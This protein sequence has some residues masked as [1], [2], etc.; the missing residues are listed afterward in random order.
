MNFHLKRFHISRDTSEVVRHVIKQCLQAFYHHRNWFM[1][2]SMVN[3]IESWNGK[4]EIFFIN[5]RKTKVNQKTCIDFLKTSLLL[6]CRRLYPDND[7]VF[8]QD[9]A[10]SHRT[11]ATPNFLRDN[12]PDFISSQVWTPHSPDLNPPDYSVWD[13][14]QE[15]VYEGRREPFAN[16][17]D[18]QNVIR[19]KWHDVD[20]QTV[21]KTIL[22]WKRRLAAVAKQNGGPIQH[23]FC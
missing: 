7:F 14:L 5:P 19:D 2:K 17:K 6:E 12:T 15:L 21:R 16:L 11:K 18:V 1:K 3:A 23:I 22:L 4:T 13:I 20:D 10:P 9:S 8:V